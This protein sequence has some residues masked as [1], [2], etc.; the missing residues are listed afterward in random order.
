MRKQNDVVENGDYLGRY[1]T[2]F[3]NL[4]DDSDLTPHEFRLLIHYYRVGRGGCWEGVRTTAKK[5]KMSVG[6]VSDVR[7]SLVQKGFIHLKKKDD[8]SVH[9]HV[10]NKAAE[11]ISKY[12]GE[13]GRSPHEHDHVQG[14]NEVFMDIAAESSGD[15]P[16]NTPIK[17]TPLRTSLSPTAHVRADDEDVFEKQNNTDTRAAGRETEMD[18]QSRMAKFRAEVMAVG[19]TVYTQ[20]M[21][22][23]FINYYSQPDGAKK[24]KM[25]WEKKRQ[26]VGWKHE[27]QLKAWATRN[28]DGIQCYLTEGQKTIAEKRQ[29]FAKSLEPYMQQYGREFLLE[30]YRYWS[31]P[32]NVPDPQYLRWEKEPYWELATRLADRFSKWNKPKY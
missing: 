25:A 28:I 27:S 4:I 26:K 31:V 6:K 23:N 30:F 29:A 17:N 20:L 22:D 5:C 13:G 12:D 7:Q 24:P 11:N 8:G 18:L 21:L 10:V 32:E 14:A 16:K 15:E 1:F 2:Q 9:I 19:A 3:P